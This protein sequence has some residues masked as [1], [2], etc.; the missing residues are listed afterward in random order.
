MSEFS[1]PSSYETYVKER[2][3]EGLSNL[4][5]PSK[6]E[7]KRGGKYIIGGVATS[8]ISTTLLERFLGTD[9]EEYKK[10]VEDTTFEKEYDKM[11]NELR[12]GRREPRKSLDCGTSD[13]DKQNELICQQFPKLCNTTR[14]ACKRFGLTGEVTREQLRRK[15]REV[16]LDLHPDKIKVKHPNWTKTQKEEASQLFRK[17]NQDYVSLN[18]E[19]SNG[20]TDENSRS[21]RHSFL[22]SSTIGFISFI[23]IMVGSYKMFVLALFK[24]AQAKHKERKARHILNIIK[25]VSTAPNLKSKIEPHQFC[26]LRSLTSCSKECKY[27]NSKQ[28]CEPTDDFMLEY[29][30]RSTGNNSSHSKHR[31]RTNK[32]K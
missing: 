7:L 18:N 21:F 8:I 12:Y 11:D 2:I 1:S 5:E 9:L 29:M 16:S 3:V 23:G 30:F 4:Y 6:T 15:L 31:H 28:K 17:I 24:A 14:S 10:F 19:F 13:M 20:A 27:N 26:L 22:L 25:L 32:M